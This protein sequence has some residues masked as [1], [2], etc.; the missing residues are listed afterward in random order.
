MET[1]VINEVYFQELDKESVEKGLINNQ[2]AIINAKVD[3]D[4]TVGSTIKTIGD[5]LELKVDDIVIFNK[6]SDE[7]YDIRVNKVE[8]AKGET[9]YIDG[10]L[11]VR[12]MDF[13]C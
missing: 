9:L 7:L 2:K 5:I 12:I 6:K 8:C 10:K 4:A 3:F 11:G 13:T 1:K